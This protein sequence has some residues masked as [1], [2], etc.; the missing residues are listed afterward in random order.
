[1]TLS[2]TSQGRR[3]DMTGM[4]R[5]YQDNERDRIAVRRRRGEDCGGEGSKRLAPEVDHNA[6][7]HVAKGRQSMVSQVCGEHADSSYE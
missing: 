5:N 6:R 1:M 7:R 2:M 4:T 3:I